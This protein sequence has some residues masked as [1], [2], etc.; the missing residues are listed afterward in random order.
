MGFEAARYEE[1]LFG[2]FLMQVP[3]LKEDLIEHDP[4]PASTATPA[5]DESI[6]E[7]IVVS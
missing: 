6:A 4:L 7:P 1:V 5:Y 3:I 2:K